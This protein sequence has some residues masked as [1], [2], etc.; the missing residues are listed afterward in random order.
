MSKK[1]LRK[2]F[3]MEI[4]KSMGRFLSIF[5]I[6]AIGVA[7]FSG[8]RSAEPDMRL[9]G[10]AYFDQHNLM[11]V[12]VISTLGLTKEDVKALEGVD[13]IKKVEAGY[14]T[15][16]LCSMNDSKKVVH[17]ASLLPTM[18]EVIVEEGRLPEAANECVVDVDFLAGSEYKMGDKMTFLSGSDNDLKDTL[19]SE[20]YTI[21]GGVSS[22]QYISYMRGSSTIGTGTVSG[23]VFVP[24]SAFDMDVY[25]EIYATVDG[26]K[27][28]TAFTDAYDD[29]VEGTI[30]H[31]KQI[32]KTR[33]NARYQEIVDEAT[34]KLNDAK[35]ELA[36]AK[37]EADDKLN[38]AK[39]KLDDGRN[40]IA[41]AKATIADGYAQISDSRN[42]LIQKQEE[43]DQGYSTLNTQT[44]T[45]NAKIAELNSA[46][47]QYNALAA[48]GATDQQTQMMLAAMQ[49]QI[50]AG[51]AQIQEAQIQMDAARW[52]L[53]DGQ[54]QI[55]NGWVQLYEAQADLE[56][57]QNELA[58]KEQ[59]LNDAQQEYED[60]KAE[61]DEKIAD[62]EKK[63]QDAEE[64][65][66]KIEHSKWYVYDRSTLTD[67]TSYGDNADRMKAIGK[68]FPVLFF[69]VAALISLTTMTR[70]VEEQR[71]LIGTLK[72]L[73]YGRRSIA[74][75]YIGYACMATISGSLAGVLIGEKILPYIIINAYGIMYQH[76]D[77]VNIPY[78][79]YYGLL[80]AITAL[81]CTLL[82]TVFSCFKE[83]REQAAELMRPPTPKQ[84]KR[85]LL[86]RVP[87]IWKRLSFIWKATVRNLIRYKKR[88]FM[89]VFGISGCMALLLVGFGLKDSIFDI[90]VLQYNEIQLYDGNI[91]LDE[92][93][94][95]AEKK[96]SCKKL[97][98]DQAVA[99]MAVNLLQQVEVTSGKVT[100]DVYL[101]VPEEE[102]SFSELVV[103]KNRVTGERYKLT[104]SGAILTEK[105]AR[106]LDVK[107]GD[108]ITIKDDIKGE[109]EVKISDIC[110]NYM[111][112][113]LY[114][115]SDLYKELYGKA[116]EY[117]SIYYKMNEV[118]IDQ[119]QTIGESILET[120]G[121][122]SVSYTV[123]MEGQMDDMLESLDIVLVVL[124]ISAG[125]LAFVV[126]YNLN[127]I[128]ITERQRELATLKVLGFF[129]NEVSAYV[130]RE[131]MI[132]TI[133]GA[134]VGMLLGKILH[135][136][137]IVTVEIDSVMF[138]RNI[139]VSSFV[140]G[141]LITIGFSLFVNGVM[142]FK[143]KR[144]DMVESLKSVE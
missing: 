88:F 108:T 99:S 32:K 140:Y 55:N 54:V 77:V 16:A 82:A 58:T 20:T 100:K 84:G 12:K 92:D 73:G 125:M 5:F 38:D 35:N 44:D 39:T 98:S 25:T 28:L 143:L 48:S 2:D 60:A 110:E 83:L 81:A 34:T 61:A 126:L 45:L 90:G 134:L 141:F 124:V 128:N 36:D 8:I 70:M 97:E 118:E 65:I 78:N 101:N 18:N 59:E 30:D 42:Q 57:G 22:P 105:M 46:K 136:F 49:Q 104:D 53:D 107:A 11:D 71:T 121:A 68:V 50:A 113:Y 67:Y 137:V 4:R 94:A 142:Y 132:L 75:K 133:V 9:S 116:P 43:I 6:V 127:N 66:S 41:D 109:L 117:N 138:G 69:L 112:H 122:L 79:L 96:E 62:G 37:T 119:L 1:A 120:K 74:G 13:G 130:Y 26:A 24:E 114:L 40:Q 31:V 10:D 131:N 80:A 17:I 72:A 123:N 95:E 47:E 93:A 56:S 63:I 29:Q 89:T 144:I 103:F 86:E 76:M 87:F 102:T 27:E 33:E 19:K 7:F 14:S 111:G 52:Q 3:Y 64:E 91:I 15:D 135:Q 21:V 115:T 129:D 106:T 23:F 51:D 85:V 139:D